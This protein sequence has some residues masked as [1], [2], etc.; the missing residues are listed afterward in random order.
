MVV[1][2]ERLWAPGVAKVETST[3]T[4]LPSS[5]TVVNQPADAPGFARECEMSGRPTPLTAT[6]LTQWRSSALRSPGTG[7]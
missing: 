2:T 5:L 1:D 3:S 4:A 7:L 6:F